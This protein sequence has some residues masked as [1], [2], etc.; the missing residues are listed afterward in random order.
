MEDILT[1]N[2]Y[3]KILENHGT[4][5]NLNKDWKIMDLKSSAQKV[6][7]STL[8]FKMAPQRVIT[9]SKT[10]GKHQVN[11]VSKEKKNDVKK[12]MQYFEVTGEAKDFYTTV[13]ADVSH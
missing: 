13:L 11:M 1:P 10:L 2:G 9:Y 12:L 6:L 4:V 8:P 7:R 5:K 3:H